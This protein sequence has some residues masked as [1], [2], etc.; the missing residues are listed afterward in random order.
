[1]VTA[2]WGP[3]RFR[4]Q[5]RESKLVQDSRFDQAAIS[6]AVTLGKL[7]QRGVPGFGVEAAGTVPSAKLCRHQSV[8]LADSWRLPQIRRGFVQMRH[9]GKGICCGAAAGI[10]AWLSG[11]CRECAGTRC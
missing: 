1:M 7:H 6:I 8:I 2:L 10:I 5:S 3:A 9:V 11:H 4:F